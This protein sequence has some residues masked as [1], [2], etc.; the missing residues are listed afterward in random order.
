MPLLAEHRD[1]DDLA[2]LERLLE[3]KNENVTQG[4]TEALYRF[5]RYRERVRDP[6]EALKD[7]GWHGLTLA[8]K[9]ILAIEELD[10]RSRME[11]LRSTISILPATIGRLRTM[12]WLRSARCSVI[13]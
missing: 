12:D 8:E 11:A 3:H 7:S 13:A 2:L 10:A 1:E 4:A 6:R 9:H 5:Y